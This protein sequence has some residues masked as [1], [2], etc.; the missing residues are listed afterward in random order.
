MIKIDKKDNTKWFE[1]FR[2][3]NDRFI[4]G[5]KGDICES[6]QRIIEKIK[7]DKGYTREE[8]IIKNNFIIERKLKLWQKKLKVQV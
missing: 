1:D 3:I 6:I 8:D 7:N 5:G 2:L 4:W